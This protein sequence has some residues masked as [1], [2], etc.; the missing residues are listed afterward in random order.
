M[1]V[2]E[3]DL[4]ASARIRN[5]A[6]AGFAA[7]GVA[8]TTIRG[9]AEAAGVSPGLVQHHFGTKAGLRQAVDEYVTSVVTEAF[10]DI[11]ALDTADPLRELADRITA[12]VRDHP[13]ALAY[14]ARSVAQ[15]DPAAVGL[16]EGFVALAR[17]QWRRLDE[18]GRLRQGV[19]LE[20]AALHIVI[21][22]LGTVLFEGA[23]SSARGTSFTDPAE[24]ERWNDAAR[25]L[26]EHGVFRAGAG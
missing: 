6:L 23:I 26:W 13:T 18:A 4:T 22:N 1:R 16:F 2:L 19:D 14:V 17:E 5:A 24:I 9:V 3:E 12:V 25:E 7:D 8:A 20:W 21:F 11:D 10:R 15:R